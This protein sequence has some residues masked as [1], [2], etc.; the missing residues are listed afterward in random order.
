M[1]SSSAI[2]KALSSMEVTSDWSRLSCTT[3]KEGTCLQGLPGPM[4]ALQEK[5]IKF[6]FTLLRF[7]ALMLLKQNSTYPDWYMQ[8][9][10]MCIGIDFEVGWIRRR[11]NR[12]KILL[13][14]NLSLSWAFRGINYCCL[15]NWVISSRNRFHSVLEASQGQHRRE[16]GHLRLYRVLEFLRHSS[17]NA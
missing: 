11:E 13:S 17:L 15:S 4:V 9:F 14:L 2:K 10:K 12:M 5:E 7:R 8:Y 6:H 1:L 3:F 16:A